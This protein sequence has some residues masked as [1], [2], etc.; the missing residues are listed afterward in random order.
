MGSS[1]TLFKLES[2]LV[3]DIVAVWPLLF[4]LFMLFP[5]WLLLLLLLLMFVVLPL[6]LMFCG[7]RVVISGDDDAESCDFFVSLL[8][9]LERD[10][11][12]SNEK[13]KETMIYG[14]Q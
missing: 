3:S 2:S 1:S 10:I 4:E 11:C 9:E 13:K 5:R 14:A 6:V 7:A 12:S 8:L